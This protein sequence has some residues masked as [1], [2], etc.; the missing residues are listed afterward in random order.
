M[1]GI[2]LGVTVTLMYDVEINIFLLGERDR[3]SI[4][5]ETS[6]HPRIETSQDKMTK[7]QEEDKEGYILFRNQTFPMRISS[8]KHSH[9]SPSSHPSA[10]PS[11]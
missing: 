7:V 10:C 2:I 5:S 9:P 6:I 1:V 3:N 8:T 4:S 11:S